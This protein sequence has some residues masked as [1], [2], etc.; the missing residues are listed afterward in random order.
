[1][2]AVALRRLV[3]W[4]VALQPRRRRHGPRPCSSVSSPVS[5][6]SSPLSL[7]S[8][9]GG[10]ASETGMLAYAAAVPCLLVLLLSWSFFVGYCLL[11]LLVSVQGSVKSFLTE[12]V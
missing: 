4:T 11:L 1:M 8:C 9:Y 7:C 2:L 5:S 6:S 10:L 12:F 3:D